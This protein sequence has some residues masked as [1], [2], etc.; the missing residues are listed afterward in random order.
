VTTFHPPLNLPPATDRLVAKINRLHY[1]ADR[2]MDAPVVGPRGQQLTLAEAQHRAKVLGDAID[3]EE[4][5]GSQRHR[6]VSRTA[7]VLALGIV[8]IVDFPIMLWLVSSVF[9]VDWA[10]PLGLDLA[11]SVVVSMLATG[12]ATAAL[13]HL[14]HDQRQNKNHR[15]QLNSNQ[16]TFGSKISIAAVTLLVV[17]IAA[18]MFV[19][20]WTEGMLSG[21]WP[22]WCLWSCSSRPGWCSG[23]P[24]GTARPSGTT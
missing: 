17:L 9:N 2:I 5:L 20:V 11:V 18:V 8:G 12:G 24:S 13:Y 4:A 7:K 16:L 3:G 15:R 10:N 19:R 21:C 22:C 1:R 6:G 14:G 23:S